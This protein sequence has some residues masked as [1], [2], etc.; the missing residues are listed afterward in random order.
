MKRQIFSSHNIIANRHASLS[1][2]YVCTYSYSSY[3]L[4]VKERYQL[5][6]PESLM[7]M[8]RWSRDHLSPGQELLIIHHLDHLCLYISG[9]GTITV[10]YFPTGPFYVVTVISILFHCT[11]ELN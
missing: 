6:I 4:L 11:V 3:S 10:V 5:D 9:A 8:H 1:D 2:V 7:F